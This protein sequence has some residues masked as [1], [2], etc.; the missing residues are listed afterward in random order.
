MTEP[1][2][3]WLIYLV[4]NKVNGKR[5]VGMTRGDRLARRRNEHYGA[6]RKGYRWPLQ[7]AIR[8]YGKDALEFSVLQ[9][10][11]SR[12]EACEA[13][14]SLIAA[15]KPE[16][17]V[18]KGGDG[19]SYW[20][21]R[22]RNPETIEKM[23]AAMLGRPGYWTGKKRSQETNAKVSAT[24]KGVKNPAAVEIMRIHGTKVREAANKVRQRPVVCLD[25]GLR[26]ESAKQ[27]SLYYGGHRSTVTV[28]VRNGWK[29]F[30][31]KFV[32]EVRP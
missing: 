30:G 29:A 18:S 24:K 7:A 21:G 1:S 3:T 19:T 9:T 2:T 28:A 12:V 25:N 31:K 4:T 8:K 32:Y 5:Y 11:T 22:K 10:C 26:F 14:I 15:M 27:A 13:E 16:Y 6:A 17:N 20:E 23:R